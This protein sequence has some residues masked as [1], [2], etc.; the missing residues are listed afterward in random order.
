MPFQ[1]FDPE[2]ERTEYR[3]CLP[4]WQQAGCTYFVTFRLSDA[5]PR[6]KRE[7]WLE[8]RAQWLD[9]RGMKSRGEFARL[10]AE[11]RRFFRQHF[12]ARMHEW[13]DAGDGACFLR[14]P[15]FATI[16]G[17]ALRYFDRQRYALGDFILMPN[18]VHLLVTPFGNWRLEKLLHSWKRHSALEINK[19]RGV[20]GSL[21]EEESFDHIVRSLEQLQFYR[22]YIRENPVKAGLRDGEYLLGCGSDD[23]TE[24]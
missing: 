1:P 13:L 3:R 15:R 20:Q 23:G 21:W 6:A 24:L 10:P 5:L 2:G 12:T 8:E 7:Q 4:H 22:R 14:E 18:H 11:E 16:V 9:A 17:G 19:L